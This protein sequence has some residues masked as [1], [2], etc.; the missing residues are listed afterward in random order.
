MPVTNCYMRISLSDM[1]F[2]QRSVKC[3][4][5][6]FYIGIN[7]IF[8]YVRKQFFFFLLNLMLPRV[9]RC[10]INKAVTTPLF[11]VTL[12]FFFIKIDRT[13]YLLVFLFFI[14][15]I[16]FLPQSDTTTRYFHSYWLHIKI[17]IFSFFLFIMHR[18]A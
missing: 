16:P 3:M 11:H 6:D 10:N 5:G 12:F 8:Y 2:Q 17:I 14:G 13:S 9:R 7:A 1:N 15:G 4:L 18:Y